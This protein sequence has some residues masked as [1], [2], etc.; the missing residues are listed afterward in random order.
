MFLL[1]YK[2]IKRIENMKKESNRFSHK[3]KGK[4]KRRLQINVSLL[5]RFLC[6]ERGID[7]SIPSLPRASL[8]KRE[9][10]ESFQINLSFSSVSFLRRERDSNPR[11]LSVQRFSRPPH[12]TTLPSLQDFL[13][14]VLFLKSDAK[15]RFYFKSANSSRVFLQF[16]FIYVLL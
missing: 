16:F 7:K 6:G 13:S 12:S 1:F 2:I 11:Y 15:V 10:D 14:E 4:R 5:F 3:K 9:T 8:Q